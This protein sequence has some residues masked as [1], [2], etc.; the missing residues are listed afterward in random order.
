MRRGEGGVPGDG[1]PARR[2]P[3]RR[4]T[5]LEE[6][7]RNFTEVLRELRVAQ[8]GVQIL[9]AFL[10]ALAFAPR[11]AE[12]D[13]FQ[14]GTYVATLLLS[15]TAMALLTTPAALHRVLFRRHAKRVIATLSSRLTLLGLFLLALALT[16]SVLLVVDFVFGRVEGAVAAGAALIMFAA[17]W[18]GLPLYIRLK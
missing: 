16:G 3:E 2:D 14:R 10:L 8:V 4:E 7:D 13:G 11:F 9:V 6:A 1:P 17:L 12:L 5:E 18:A 15:V